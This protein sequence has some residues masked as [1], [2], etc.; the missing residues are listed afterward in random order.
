VIEKLAAV[1]GGIAA[2]GVVAAM[3]GVIAGSYA[4]H[5]VTGHLRTVVVTRTVPGPVVSRQTVVRIIHVHV[6]V[7][8]QGKVRVVTVPVTT[9]VITRAA[10]SPSPCTS[11]GSSGRCREP[12]QS[13]V[14]G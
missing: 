9:L 4:E 3:S 8:K 6:V 1:K 14:P 10:P 5:A 2:A 11:E 13:A 12:P 7:R